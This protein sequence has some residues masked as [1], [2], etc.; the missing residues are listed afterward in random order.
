LPNPYYRKG[1]FALHP[2]ALLASIRN[3]AALLFA[4]APIFLLGLKNPDSRRMAIAASIPISLFIAIWVL[5]SDEMDYMMR[6]Q[7]PILP[8]GLMSAPL[9]LKGSILETSRK[10]SSSNSARRIAMYLT[11]MWLVAA[12]AGLFRIDRSGIAADDGKMLVGE[13]LRSYGPRRVIA[14]TEAGLL[15]LYSEWSALDTWGLNDRWI[16][17]H[18]GL[19]SEQYLDR[20]KPD[21]IAMHGLPA[22]RRKV[23]ESDWGRLSA[24][25]AWQA[26]LTVLKTYAESHRYRVAAVDGDSAS[27]AMIYYVRNDA[28][29]ASSIV[30]SIRSAIAEAGRRRAG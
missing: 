24:R 15:P 9:F 8:I 6:F 20:W 16:A 2:E 19:I 17:H 29:D 3:A 13:A 12:F 21:V 25:P 23:P 27:D 26:M 4:L 18:N 30:D 5:I 1:G 22:P 7:Y 10:P 14:T 28:P 11:S